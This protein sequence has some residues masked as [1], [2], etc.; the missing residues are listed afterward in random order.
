MVLSQRLVAVSTLVWVT[1][2]VMVWVVLSGKVYIAPGQTATVSLTVYPPPMAGPRIL[3][4]AVDATQ[5]EVVP[6]RE[7]P[8][9]VPL[10]PKPD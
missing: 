5:L 3:M 6:V 7:K 8:D 9:R 2:E 4:L 1:I 10:L